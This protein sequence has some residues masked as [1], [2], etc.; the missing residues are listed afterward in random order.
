MKTLLKIFIPLLLFTACKS[1]SYE[2]AVNANQDKFY[3]D[4][5]QTALLLVDFKNLSQAA[6]DISDLAPKQAYAK[7]VCNFADMV[8]SDQ[9][10]RKVPLKLLALKKGVKLPTVVSRENQQ[11]YHQLQN[12]KDEKTFDKNYCES[13]KKIFGT[14][15]NK[16]DSFL[17]KN[18]EGPV[19]DFLVKQTGIY[20]SY[21]TKINEIQKYSEMKEP[22][23][24]TEK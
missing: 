12:I 21:L 15:I 9:Q 18:D 24:L 5:K 6:S 7:D 22:Q 1:I 16:C 14:I 20:K 11:V 23:Q 17:N 8:V 4:E 19:R 13:E 10:S 2:S 3:G